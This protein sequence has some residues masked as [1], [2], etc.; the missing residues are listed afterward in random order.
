MRAILHKYPPF[1]AET[2]ASGESRVGLPAA[3]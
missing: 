1:V 3:R 2:A